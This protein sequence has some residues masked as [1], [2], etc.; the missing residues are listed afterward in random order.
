MRQ[1]SNGG[2]AQ[3]Q[4]VLRDKRDR[5]LSGGGNKKAINMA[6]MQGSQTSGSRAFANSLGVA[7]ASLKKNVRKLNSGVP[8]K[9]LIGRGGNNVMLQGGHYM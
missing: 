5:L 9:I 1:Y 6:H 4:I 3:Q 7:P 2:V 8:A